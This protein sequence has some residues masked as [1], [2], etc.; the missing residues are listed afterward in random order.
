VS[1]G[2]FVSRAAAA[3]PHIRHTWRIRP[4]GHPLNVSGPEGAPPLVLLHGFGA[5]SASWYAMAGELS[6]A[7]QVHVVDLIG[8]AGRSVAAS[9]HSIPV[10]HADALVRLLLGFLPGVPAQNGPEQEHI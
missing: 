7:W 1:N 6:R 2:T 9:H 5:T 8:D 4:A 10:E 3:G